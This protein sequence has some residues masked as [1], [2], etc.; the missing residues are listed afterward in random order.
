M[1]TQARAREG[2]W[3]TSYIN[4]AWLL[5][6]KGRDITAVG[7]TVIRRL[8]DARDPAVINMLKRADAES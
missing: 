1:G 5:P 6:T 8:L 3:D 4:A 7:D 2:R